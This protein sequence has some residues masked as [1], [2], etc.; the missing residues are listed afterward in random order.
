MSSVA[1]LPCNTSWSFTICRRTLA[2]RISLAVQLK[3]NNHMLE[4][5]CEA[6][7]VDFQFNKIDVE[8]A[9]SVGRISCCRAAT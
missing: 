9:I 2:C 3:L 4:G 5:V 1:L 8:N 6:G 7:L